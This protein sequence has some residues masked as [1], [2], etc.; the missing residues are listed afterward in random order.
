[1]KQQQRWGNNAREDDS[2]SGRSRIL[3]A[4]KRCYARQGI[5]A[6]TLDEI[7]GEAKITRRTIYRYFHNKKAIIQAVVD[8]QARDF[9]CRMRDEIH[10][11]ALDF[12]TQLQHYIVYLVEYGQQA[13]GYQLLLGSDNV[14]ASTGFYLAS[15][16]NYKLLESLI[17]QPFEDAQAR[18]AIRSDISYAQLMAWIGRVVFS[19]IQVPAS[20]PVLVAQIRDFVIPALRSAGELVARLK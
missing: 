10:D 5:A 8:E 2:Q 4:A 18:G 3:L 11:P 6:T 20:T 12:S 7:A 17:R 1:M 9:L 19:Y 13:P 15:S 14:D 16:D